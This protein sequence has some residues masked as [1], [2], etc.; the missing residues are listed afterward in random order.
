VI[1]FDDRASTWDGDLQP[2]GDL[3]VVDLVE[4]DG[5]FHEGGDVDGHNGFKAAELAK[6]LG[7]AGFAEIEFGPRVRGSTREAIRC[8]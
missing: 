4:E 8:E 3:C 2:G 6:L 7:A 1:S 5:S